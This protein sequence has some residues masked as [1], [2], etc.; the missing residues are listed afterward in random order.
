MDELVK[1]IPKLPEEDYILSAFHQ[2]QERQSVD[3]GGFHVA[4]MNDCLITTINVL[5]LKETP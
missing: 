2:L 3:A 1:T 4:S 5:L